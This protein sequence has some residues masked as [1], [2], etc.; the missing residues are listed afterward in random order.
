MMKDSTF[1]KSLIG[2]ALAAMTLTATAQANLFDG[3]WH[4]SVTPYIFLP[5]INQSVTL[6]RR[7]GQEVDASASLSPSDWWSALNMAFM[8]NGEA[9][10]GDWSVFT[11]F[12]YADYGGVKSK[13]GAL[14]IVNADA[15]LDLKMNMWTTVGSYTAWRSGGSHFDTFA[16]FRYLG[17]K[18]TLSFNVNAG[19]IGLVSE[20]ASGDDKYWDFIAGVK[21]EANLSEDGKWFLPYY[22]DIG[23]GSDNWTWQ[24]QAGVGYRFGWGNV[25]LSLRN[26]SYNFDAHNATMRLTGGQ[27]GASFVF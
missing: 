8:I 11:D 21:G 26:V 1:K 10:K 4:F 12:L 5:H 23:T 14:G 18:D 7:N 13:A 16:G 24:A 17:L 9:R 3:E 15:R 22:A 20:Q 19:P 6:E 2:A 25:N 27:I